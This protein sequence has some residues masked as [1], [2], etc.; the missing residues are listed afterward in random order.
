MEVP[1][2]QAEREDD[3]T[4]NGGTP[5]LENGLA[6]A[7]TTGTEETFIGRWKTTLGVKPQTERKSVNREATMPPVKPDRIEAILPFDVNS[8]LPVQIDHPSICTSDTA[9]P[10][11]E[12]FELPPVSEKEPTTDATKV[13]DGDKE[14][15]FLTV[16]TATEEPPPAVEILIDSDFVATN[17]DGDLA[18][19]A[20]A[21]K[22]KGVDP[23]G[24]GSSPCDPK[25]MVIP[26]D[27]SSI[28]GSD[29]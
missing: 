20:L 29:Q 7:P 24:Y 22:G 16:T 25:L 3:R 8:V 28:V 14:N 21:D 4:S 15:N 5:V 10:T 27:A 17:E 13:G 2:L 1:T 9:L 12:P 23:R 11:D 19:V 26:A 6:S 18:T